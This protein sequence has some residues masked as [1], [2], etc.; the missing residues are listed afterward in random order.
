MAGHEFGII[1]ASHRV[2]EILELV[3]LAR[4]LISGEPSRCPDQPCY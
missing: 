2:V 1:N 4:I 3:G